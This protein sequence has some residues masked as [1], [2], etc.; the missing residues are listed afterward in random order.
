M[1]QKIS[2]KSFKELP[3]VA[4]ITVIIIGFLLIGGIAAIFSDSSKK[5]TNE[6]TGQVD[7]PTQEMNILEAQ[8][9]CV[10]LTMIGSE[11]AGVE[12]S[13]DDAQKHCLAM[14]DSP[15]REKVF[16]DTITKEWEAN[17]NEVYYGKTIEKIYEERKE[18][19]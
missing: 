19:L 9:K 1:K 13:V 6:A 11:K 2:T 18:S 4:K 14:W 8:K 17:K 7:N 10:V 5:N 12:M 3:K 15:E 16:K